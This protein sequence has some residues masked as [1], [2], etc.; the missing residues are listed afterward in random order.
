M[1]FGALA[2]VSL[3]YPQLLGNGKGVVQL[4]ALGS[5]SF[6]LLVVLLVLK[7]LATAACLGAG[8]PGG[9]FTPSLT[10]GVLLAGRAGDDL[11]RTSG[12][13]CRSAATR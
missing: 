13:A 2:V 8:S 6:G 5:Y 9:L 7:P 4:E 1:V 3:Q 10:I 11:E 12:A